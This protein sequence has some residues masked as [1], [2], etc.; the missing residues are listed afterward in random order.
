MLMKWRLVIYIEAHTEAL[1]MF[2]LSHAA[3]FALVT[4]SLDH[5]PTYSFPIVPTKSRSMSAA[6][7]VRM[8]LLGKRLT[9]LSLALWVSP[10]PLVMA[11]RG[12]C[13]HLAYDNP[14]Q[15]AICSGLRLNC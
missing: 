11:L 8:S 7:P 6:L 12:A 9:D 4:S 15:F 13:L 2:G 3:M 14:P 5:A 1:K 10:N